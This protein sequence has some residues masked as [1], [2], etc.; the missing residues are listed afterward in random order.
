[1]SKRSGRSKRYRR[2][3]LEEDFSIINRL[4]D[5]RQKIK[6]VY[7]TSKVL[8]LQEYCVRKYIKK[9][10]LHEQNIE[11]TY[12]SDE[13]KQMILSVRFGTYEIAQKNFMYWSLH[14][15][16]CKQMKKCAHA[17]FRVF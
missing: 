11:E 7:T 12:V 17:D 8:S 13:V 14:C 16:R 10:P 1:M 6:S 15:P 5:N 2:K 4:F 3:F 9:N